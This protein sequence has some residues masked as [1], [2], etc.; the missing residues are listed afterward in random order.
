M[1]AM[2][3]V[4]CTVLPNEASDNEETKVPTAYPAQLSKRGPPKLRIWRGARARPSKAGEAGASTKR[5]F[6][7]PYKEHSCIATPPPE[8]R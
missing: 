4:C 6:Q 7:T 1:S 2:W 5:I 3:H 8:S